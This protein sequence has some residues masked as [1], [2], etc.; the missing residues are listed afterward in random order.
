MQSGANGM[1]KS[2]AS[3]RRSMKLIQPGSFISMKGQQKIDMLRP[4]WELIW[5]AETPSG[6]LVMGFSLPQDY[7]RNEHSTTL[8]SGN[9]NIQF[10][11]WSKSSL[12]FSQAERH[13]LVVEFNR[14]YESKKEA[15]DLY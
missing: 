15:L 2:I 1:F 7:S 10:P 9:I 8:T 13:R 11:I 4:S 12:E 5:P 6:S 14:L 3:Q